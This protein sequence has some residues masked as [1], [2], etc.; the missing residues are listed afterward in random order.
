MINFSDF[1]GKFD[2]YYYNNHSD[3]TVYSDGVQEG[4]QYMQLD[5]DGK[6]ALLIHEN[7]GGVYGNDS[8]EFTSKKVAEKYSAMAKEIGQLYQLWKLYNTADEFLHKNTS[9]GELKAAVKA[10]I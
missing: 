5:E 8:Y 6:E 7:E 10:A 9:F 3:G 1:L 4:T 2:G